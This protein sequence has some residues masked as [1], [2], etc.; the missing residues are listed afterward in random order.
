MVTVVRQPL[1]PAQICKAKQLLLSPLGLQEAIA[2]DL[3]RKRGR[4][5]QL[6]EWGSGSLEGIGVTGEPAWQGQ[7]QPGLPKRPHVK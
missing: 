6:W 4:M 1:G 3:M 7:R 2:A 5:A